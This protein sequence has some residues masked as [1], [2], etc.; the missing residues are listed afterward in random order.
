MSPRRALVCAPGIPGGDEHREGIM[1][2]IRTR[3]KIVSLATVVRMPGSATR[4]LRPCTVLKHPLAVVSDA[5]PLP[6][7][8]PT[9]RYQWLPV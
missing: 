8:A 2:K 3:H 5:C 9:R 6:I 1:R 7:V 4:L